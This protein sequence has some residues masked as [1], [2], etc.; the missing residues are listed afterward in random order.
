ML[1]SGT[2]S[3]QL[4]IPLWC[5]QH[6]DDGEVGGEESSDDF[7]T[8]GDEDALF[9]VVHRSA[10]RSVRLQLR[11]VERRDVLYVEVHFIRRY[12]TFE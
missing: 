3:K 11:Q 1:R 6:G 5:Q 7:L 2:R 10:E 4:L 12:I 8:F 9:D